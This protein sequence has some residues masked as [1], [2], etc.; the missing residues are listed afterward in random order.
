[1]LAIKSMQG[2]GSGLL[3]ANGISPLIPTLFLSLLFLYSSA[4][5]LPRVG[6]LLGWSRH[7]GGSEV[8]NL[9][10]N[11]GDPALGSIP[12]SGRSPGGGHG[13]HSSVLAWRAL[14]NLSGE[15]HGHRSLVGYK[16]KHL[17]RARH[18]W[19]GMVMPT[20]WEPY[21]YSMWQYFTV[22]CTQ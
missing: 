16:P 1:M 4:P 3:P 7:P 13:N 12:G 6:S 14:E 18:K 8:R 22:P 10:A 17:E 20:S 2:L 15:S 5:P 9:P 21:V 19:A 11:A